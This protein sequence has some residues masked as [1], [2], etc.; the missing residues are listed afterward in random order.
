MEIIEGWRGQVVMAT[1]VTCEDGAKESPGEN[2]SC[3]ELVL[4]EEV[5]LSLGLSGGVG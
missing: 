2:S 3:I 4:Q 1:C 5:R